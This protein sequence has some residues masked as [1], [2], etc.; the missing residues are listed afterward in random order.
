MERELNGFIYDTK[1]ELKMKKEC[2]QLRKLDMREVM[3]WKEMKQ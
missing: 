1:D 2:M 3:M